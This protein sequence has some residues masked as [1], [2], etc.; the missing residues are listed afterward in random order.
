VSALDGACAAAG[1]IDE[2]QVAA[3]LARIEQR[4]EETAADPVRLAAELANGSLQSGDPLAA[5]GRAARLRSAAADTLRRLKDLIGAAAR[6][7]V[8]PAAAR[9]AGT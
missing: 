1:A 4:A 8:V 5:F 7:D 3:A 9:P 6:I 2:G